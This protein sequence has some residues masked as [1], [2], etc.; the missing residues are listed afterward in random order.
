MNN[1][2]CQ[3]KEIISGIR[4]IFCKRLVDSKDFYLFATTVFTYLFSFQKYVYLIIK[5]QI[6]T[7]WISLSFN[8]IIN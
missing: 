8:V 6:C 1:M 4:D 3:S 7:L 5:H 2:N